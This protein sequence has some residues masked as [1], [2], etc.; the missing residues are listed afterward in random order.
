MARGDVLRAR[1]DQRTGRGWSRRRISRPA[2]AK[3]LGRERRLR[4]RV[5]RPARA[6]PSRHGRDPRRRTRQPQRAASHRAHATAPRRRGRRATPAR[7]GR[8]GDHASTPAA[9]RSSRRSSMEIQKRDMAGGAA[10]LGA[11]QAIAAL[12]PA[13]RGARLRAAA[14]NMPGGRRLQAGRRAADLRRQD[15]RGAEHRRRGP[16]GAR[17]RARLRAPRAAAAAAPGWIV[18]I[19]TLTGAVTT[20]LGRASPASWATIRSWCGADRG[21]RATPA[22]RSGS[23]RSSTSTRGD[24]QPVADLKNTGDGTAGLDL[25]RALPA[26]VRRRRA[27]GAPRHRGGRVH[28]QGAAL[29]AARRGRLG[30]ADPGRPGRARGAR[31]APG[32]PS[33]RPRASAGPRRR[34]RGT[35]AD[36]TSP[37][38]AVTSTSSSMR[39]P[40]PRYASGTPSRSVREVEAGLDGEHH[41]GLERPRARRRVVGADVVHVHAEPVAGAVHVERPVGAVSRSPLARAARAARARAGRRPGRRAAASCDVL[42]GRRPGAPRAIAASCGA[43]DELVERRCAGVKSAPTGNVRVTSAQ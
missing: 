5:L 34:S 13:D 37:P 43:T 10:V 31:A 4:V 36:S 21:R 2:G 25:R 12:A 18:D 26:R 3:R 22:S 24:G 27:L 30:R 29:R 19:A 20:A 39:T 42:E 32:R 40:M 9:C 23:C 33:A 16:A 1:S 6:A 28:R 11:M 38:P 17:R 15:H 41:A 35:P 14:E 7:A 8:Q